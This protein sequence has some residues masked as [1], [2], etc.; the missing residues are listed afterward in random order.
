MVFYKRF[1][2]FGLI[3]SAASGEVSRCAWGRFTESLVAYGYF[4]KYKPNARG[5]N[6]IE[7]CKVE[8]EKL[9]ACWGIEI[10]FPDMT[11]GMQTYKTPKFMK[12]ATGEYYAC[13]DPFVYDF[14]Q[15]KSNCHFDY[16]CTRETA[17]CAVYEMGE[18]KTCFLS[19][20]PFP[21]LN[22]G[23]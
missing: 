4:T 7:E 19:E 23:H 2:L 10:S 3:I 15:N 16:P 8:C 18:M 5:P 17:E 22:D 6:V 9:S 11:C 12:N 13:L 1:V 21:W 20:E 14:C